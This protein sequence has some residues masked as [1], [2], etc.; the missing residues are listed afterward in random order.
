MNERVEWFDVDGA[1]FWTARSGSGPPAVW[2]HGGPGLWDY[3]TP[4]AAMTD[5]LVTTY[6]YDQ[7]GCGRSTGSGPHSVARSVQD[8]EALRTRWG[9][10]RFIVAG[11]SWGAQ[12]AL[13]YALEY[14]QHV[15]G[16]I[17]VSGTG[18]DTSWRDEFRA[19]RARRLGPDGE[20]ERKELEARLRSEGTIEVEHLFCEVQWS[21]DFADVATAR[22]QARS[23]LVPGLRVNRQ[24]NAELGADAVRATLDPSLE[25]SVRSLN[26]PALVIHGSA[27]PR[28]YRVAARLA[29]SLPHSELVLLDGAGHYPWIEAPDLFGRVLRGYLLT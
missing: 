12:L 21:T 24:I 14:P 23:L 22:E 18:T 4:V 28:P 1:R 19:N 25:D 20:R 8:L 16:L 13:H 17:Y 15:S 11:H 9:L 29:E 10:D 6:R 26:M 27:D 2:C 5:D 7:R 3:F